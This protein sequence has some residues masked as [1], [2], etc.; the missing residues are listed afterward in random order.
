MASLRKL[1]GKYYA[2]FSDAN[3]QPR[4]KSVPLGTGDVRAARKRVNELERL[5]DR[6]EFDPWSVARSLPWE[7]RN[8]TLA[9]V[10]AGFLTDRR[11]TC[12]PTTLRGYDMACRQ[13]LDAAPGGVYLDA[14]RPA[15]VRRFIDAQKV[16]RQ[17][18]GDGEVQTRREPVADATK[19]QRLRHVKAFVRWAHEAGLPS[20]GWDPLKGIALPRA[21]RRLPAFL[22]PPDLD[23]VLAAIDASTA[24]HKASGH[25]RDGENLWLK[26]VILV[27]AYTGLRL[28]ELCA[29]RWSWVDLG[30]R[31]LHVRHSDG[32]RTKGGR[33]RTV[34]LAGPALDAIRRL[35]AEREARG[36]VLDGP[37]FPGPRGNGI[38]PNRTSRRF[39]HFVR[40]AKLDDRLRFHSLRH[41]CGSML[42]MA[43]VPGVVIKEVLGH[44]SVTTTA[45][46]THA[47]ADHV[48][49]EMERAFSA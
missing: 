48:R 26:D 29:A 38:G 37:L 3:R 43:N 11:E 16:V 5:Y 31:S 10:V 25:A 15:H 8:L 32:F 20:D 19:R 2:Y 6:A 42:A 40:L 33:E 22:T 24:I 18:G 17:T 9:D 35:H 30:A 21:E 4:Q 7:T 41:S 13:L 14:L 23:R 47:A 49:A 39:K 34:P 28:G 45:I 27:A 12:R 46:Y 44:A 1:R 36:D